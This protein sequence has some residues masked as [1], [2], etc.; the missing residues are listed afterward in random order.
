LNRT[1]SH[2]N[3]GRSRYH[4]KHT[5]RCVCTNAMR[6]LRKH[7]SPRDVGPCRSA[8]FFEFYPCLSRACLGK[9][10]VF[11][12][13]WRK[14]TRFLTDSQ[15]QQSHRP[16]LQS[17]GHGLQENGSTVACFLVL[18]LCLSRACLG[19]MMAFSCINGSKKTVSLPVSPRRSASHRRTRHPTH[20][21]RRPRTQSG[22]DR[23][24]PPKKTVRF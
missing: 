21:R 6:Q 16:A 8:S 23:W 4:T 10:V 24:W 7:K 2:T 17:H 12:H 20:T 14:R 19:K 15:R 5:Q 18:S 13:K 3:I 22:R 9:M 11:I 1:G